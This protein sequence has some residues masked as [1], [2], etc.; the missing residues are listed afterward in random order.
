MLV[1][2]GLKWIVTP[3]VSEGR[4]SRTIVRIRVSTPWRETIAGKLLRETTPTKK[5]SS[6]ILYSMHSRKGK[7]LEFPNCHMFIM[8]SLSTYRD[9]LFNSSELF[10]ETYCVLS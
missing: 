10:M 7:H 1:D 5:D 8:S 2:V 6:S 9:S 4:P 3:Y